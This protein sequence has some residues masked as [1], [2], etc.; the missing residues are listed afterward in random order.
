MNSGNTFYY[1]ETPS[2]IDIKLSAF[3]SIQSIKFE[4]PTQ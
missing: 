3:F 4:G 1:H 2:K